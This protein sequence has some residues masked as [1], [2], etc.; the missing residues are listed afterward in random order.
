M[1]GRYSVTS[2]VG[3]LPLSLQ[4]GFGKMEE[5]L[6]GAHDI[7]VHWRDA[8]F[9]DNIPVLMGLI[10]WEVLLIITLSKGD[11][12]SHFCFSLTH[13]FFL[14]LPAPLQHLELDLHGAQQRGGAALLP[15][16]LQGPLPHPAGGWLAGW[17]ARAGQGWVAGWLSLLSGGAAAMQTA[18]SR[19]SM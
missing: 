9:Q 17:L 13:L 1:G 5:F 4:Y 18:Y 7:D 15:G 12:P 3:L 11:A 8:P 10:R 14:F 6:R 19:S 16:A 2:A